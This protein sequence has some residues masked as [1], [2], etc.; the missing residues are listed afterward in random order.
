VLFL[1]PPPTQ[2]IPLLHDSPGQCW[3]PRCDSIA[4]FPLPGVDAG[5]HC[6]CRRC[7]CNGD[8]LI[9]F[10]FGGCCC[11]NCS[12]C[13]NCCYCHC[14]CQTDPRQRRQQLRPLLRLRR[15]QWW[16]WER[17]RRPP[18]QLRRLQSIRPGLH[19]CRQVLVEGRR[20]LESAAA[21]AAA[22]ADATAA[23][24]AT[25]AA[26]C[27]YVCVCVC[28]RVRVGVCVGVRACVWSRLLR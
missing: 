28:S 8:A 22:A 5:L 17:S 1:A 12:N 18:L 15:L 10:Q 9:W 26:V 7:C 21:D 23:A 6:W 11:S 14:C 4:L 24:E 3:L 25:A 13:S 20:G 16:R 19:Q 27:N 2:L